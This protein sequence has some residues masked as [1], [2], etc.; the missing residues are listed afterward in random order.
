MSEPRSILDRHT[1]RAAESLTRREGD[2]LR[3]LACGH[4]CRIG[5]GR[6]G[7]CQVRYVEDGQLRVPFGYVAGL[8]IDPIEKKPFHHVLPGSQALS[9]GML[10]CDLHCDYCQNWD[11]SQVLRD[12]DATERLRPMTRDYIVGLALERKVPVVVSTYNEPLITVEWSTA[13]FERAKEHGLK[14]G[15]VSNGNATPEV[16]DWL[17]PVCDL[18]KVD[19]KSFSETHYRELGGTLHSVLRSLEGIVERG[20]WLEVVT[21]VVPGFNDSKKELRD[22]ASFLADLDVEIPWHVTAFRP[23]YKRLDPDPTPMPLLHRAWEIGRE[24]GL[25]H[26]YVGNMPGAFPEAERTRC[27]ACGQVLIE[28]NGYRVQTPGLRKGHCTG[29]GARLAGVFGY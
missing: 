28:R 7:V 12:P 15:F 19:L 27:A 18:Y 13:I 5:E 16:L 29:C 25:R 17:R 20:F 23:L 14:T 11:T 24:V 2:Q 8:A 26:V 9:F 6:R 21:L 10:G 22:I 4:R 3:C 1:A